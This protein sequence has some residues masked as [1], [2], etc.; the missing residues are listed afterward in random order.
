MVDKWSDDF[1]RQGRGHHRRCCGVV[2]RW[3]NGG[4]A[5]P[6]EDPPRFDFFIFNPDQ[7]RNHV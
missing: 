7:Q 2:A 6:H 4:A 1:R 5:V 3:R